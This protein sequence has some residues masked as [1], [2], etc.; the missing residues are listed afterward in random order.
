MKFPKDAKAF[1]FYLQAMGQKIGFL[2]FLLRAGLELELA[3]AATD[4]VKAIL[5]SGWCDWC[6]KD[7]HQKMWYTR[8]ILAVFYMKYT[9]GNGMEWRLPQ[10]QPSWIKHMYKH[11]GR[12]VYHPEKRGGGPKHLESRAMVPP[13]KEV[14]G[15]L[16]ADWWLSLVPGKKWFSNCWVNEHV[17]S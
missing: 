3:A 15:H 1:S 10:F 16:P 9:D 14:S 4:Q 2:P 13:L 12:E 7:L 5:V 17:P 8:N 6:F 11:V